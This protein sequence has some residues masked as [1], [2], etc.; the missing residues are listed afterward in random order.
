MRIA[1]LILAAALFVL[2]GSPSLAQR[3]FP[4]TAVIR[5]ENIWLRVDPA[6]DT[7]VLAYLQRGDPIRV[8][9]DA[10][11]ADGDAF[12][13]IEVVETGETGWVRDLAVDPRSLTLVATLP[14]VVV[15]E[16]PT[17]ETTGRNA[18][19]RGNQRTGA[20][21]RAET[22]VGDEPRAD[23]NVAEP[24]GRNARPNRE[25][26]QGEAAVTGEPVQEEGEATRPGYSAENPAP[27][28][29]RLAGGGAIVRLLNGSFAT[30][31]GLSQPKGGYK[32]L[33]IETRIEGDD[34]EGHFF[35]SSNFSGQDA[36]TGAGHDSAFVMGDT[37]GSDAQSPGEYVTGTIVL[38]VQET[39][40]RVIV[41]Y[42][43]KPIDPE[44]LFW[45]Y[46]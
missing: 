28:D 12:Y 34:P 24:T 9:G 45:I 19:P 5:G 36:D 39:A 29:Q 21:P 43:P 10:V 15:D 4:A 37:L 26:P 25:R 35:D 17:D 2:S 40:E 3:D 7:E 11:A 14:E 44:D 27:F 42:D 16:P 33:V 18:R 38:E 23:T 8:T 1:I 20:R 6:E 22:V 41:K 30:E 31:Y 13:P 46:E 32:Y